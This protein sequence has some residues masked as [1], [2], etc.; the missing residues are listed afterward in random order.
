MGN[1][2][3]RTALGLLTLS[4]PM[5]GQKTQCPPPTSTCGGDQCPASGVDQ[6]HPNGKYW[7]CGS[8]CRGRSIPAECLRKYDPP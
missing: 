7:E 6:Q 3:G 1:F 8:L 4:S 5:F 2:I